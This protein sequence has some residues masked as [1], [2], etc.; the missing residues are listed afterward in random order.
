MRRWPRT[1]ESLTEELRDLGGD[2]ADW[3]HRMKVARTDPHVRAAHAGQMSMIERAVAE[4]LATRLGADQETDPYPGVLAAAAVSVLR[5]CLVFWAASGGPAPLGQL[6]D[7]AFG[8]LADGLPDNP[9]DLRAGT[10]WR[11]VSAYMTEVTEK[12]GR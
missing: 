12:T 8:A 4:G 5:A 3:L 2:P 9:G 7:Q 10:V 1:R 11:P 6:I